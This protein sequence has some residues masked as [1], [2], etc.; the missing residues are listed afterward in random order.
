MSRDFF[1][2]TEEEFDES[3]HLSSREIWEGISKNLMAFFNETMYRF[4]IGCRQKIEGAV[5]TIKHGQEMGLLDDNDV[6]RIKGEVKILESKLAAVKEYDSIYLDEEGALADK[7]KNPK[8]FLECRK[9]L[10]WE[11]E[12]MVG[13]FKEEFLG[14]ILKIFKELVDSMA[15]GK[16]L[17]KFENSFIDR[18]GGILP[19]RKGTGVT[20]DSHKEIHPEFIRTLNESTLG[21]NVLSEGF[22]KLLKQEREIIDDRLYGGKKDKP[23]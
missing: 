19:V 13:I 10:T 21:V 1:I 8:K 16:L 12:K 14:E 7:D 3:R 9:R 17:N 23:Y 2:K 22:F 5:G 6:K 20:K 11:Q 18:D 4:E 15:A